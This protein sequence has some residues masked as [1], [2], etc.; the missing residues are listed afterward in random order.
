[1]RLTKALAGLVALPVA[2]AA[3]VVDLVTGESIAKPRRE[4]NTR[5]VI[6]AMT[7]PDR[8]DSHG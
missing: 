6:E 8:E 7:R 5:L 2:A 4:S 3:D 1:M